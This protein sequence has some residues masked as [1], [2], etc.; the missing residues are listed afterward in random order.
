V[1]CFLGVD[2]VEGGDLGD[3]GDVGIWFGGN[4]TGSRN[5]TLGFCSDESSQDKGSCAIS[6]A[7]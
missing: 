6:G 5:A 3:G 7:A 1:L 2:V 4:F